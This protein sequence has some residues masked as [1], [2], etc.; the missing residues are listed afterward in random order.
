MGPC[1]ATSISRMWRAARFIHVTRPR[2]LPRWDR[3]AA[4]G[5]ADTLFQVDVWVSFVR[6]RL[7]PVNSNYEASVMDRR[8]PGRPPKWP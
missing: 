1:T 4:P 5:A 7:H 8:A 2:N 6:S 3:D